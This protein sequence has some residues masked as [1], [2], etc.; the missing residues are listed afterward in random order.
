MK[1]IARPFLTLCILAIPLRL[2]AQDD[3]VTL[4][5][6]YHDNNGMENTQIINVNKDTG[7]W[8]VWDDKNQQFYG[9]CPIESGSTKQICTI[10]NSRFQYRLESFDRNGDGQILQTTVWRNSGRYERTKE[11]VMPTTDLRSL[12]LPI[13]PQV[14]ESGAC[15]PGK[16]PTPRPTKF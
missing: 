5:C 14:I 3:T 8:S 10:S 4:H 15:E 9:W 11:E 12:G 7:A 1:F 13:G 16:A 2:M 6:K